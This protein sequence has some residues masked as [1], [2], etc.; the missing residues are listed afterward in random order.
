MAL[1]LPLASI[2]AG[3]ETAHIMDGPHGSHTKM[4]PRSRPPVIPYRALPIR[5]RGTAVVPVDPPADGVSDCSQAINDAISALP[6]DGGT[7]L[8]RYHR[9][10]RVNECIYMINTT[11]KSLV[12]G[13][14]HYYGIKL[15][16]NM[17]LQFEPGVQLMAMPNNVPRAYI[18]FAHSVHDLEIA[19]GALIGERYT[20]INSGK[21]TDEWGYGIS[22]AGVTGVTVR[23]THISDCEG[24]GICIA[25]AG[26]PAVVPTDVI[27][28]DVVCTGNRRQGVSITSGNG[29]SLFD[30][31]FSY[32]HGTAPA[33][34]VDIEGSVS[35]VAIDNCILEG[36]QGNGVEM[37]AAKGIKITDVNI[38]NSVLCSNYSGVYVGGRVS[39]VMDTGT[40]YGNAIY[41]N[42]S[43]GIHLGGLT[44]KDFTI[45]G[46]SSCDPRNNS[47]ANNHVTASHEVLFPTPDGTSKRGYIAGTDMSLSPTAQKLKSN[48]LI[49]WNN[50]YSPAK[51][52]SRPSPHPCTGSA[53]SGRGDNLFR[54]P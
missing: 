39:S 27:L 46:S 11:A 54:R 45:G 10:G 31:E 32:T 34:G 12:S 42:R 14:T 24:D 41:Q 23:S 29:I 17:L 8:V 53:P 21:G 33:D 13:H 19:N 50:F 20:H 4:E 30:S 6:E 36:N 1:V 2:T 22:L 48:N 51:K 15:R 43:A 38:T 44:T 37:N 28:W 7:V 52:S 25:R 9:T 47:F 3:A 5:K 16:S 49:G 18:I 40:I 26:T 35:N